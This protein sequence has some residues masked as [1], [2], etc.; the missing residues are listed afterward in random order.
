[1]SLID[2]L[3][4]RIRSYGSARLVV[5]FSGGV[6]SAVVL[7]LSGRALGEDRV[8]ATTAISPSYPAGELEQARAV[9]QGLG[10][11]HQ[12]VRTAELDREEYA[13]NDPSRCFHCK[14]ELYRV[15]EPIAAAY[16]NATIVTGA[17]ADDANQFRPGLIA[18]DRYRVR[19]PLLEA[20]VG[21]SVIR[22]IARALNLT[23]V[24]K[25]AL[26][27]LSSRVAY[28]IRITPELL[29]RIDQA[30]QAVRSLG[31]SAVRVRHLG[32]SAN[33]EVPKEEIPELV[34]H[35]RFGEVR[36]LLLALGWATVTIDPVGIRSGGMNQAIS[37]EARFKALRRAQLLL[38][39]EASAVDATSHTGRA[40][41]RRPT[42]DYSAR[43]R[44]PR[45][46]P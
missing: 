1:M 43:S 30:E 12:T 6:D 22:Q 7:A 9:A 13:R 34:Q 35:P 28:G 21:K 11:R 18:G 26:P 3:Q 27:C 36:Q 31:C 25:P 29:A 14:V 4:A 33:I 19:S 46:L 10:V 2:S 40:G 41:T 32:A 5:A 37:E 15:L 24:D 42:A 44:P 45:E 39:N 17:N 23:V 16:E 8:V 20:G 38:T